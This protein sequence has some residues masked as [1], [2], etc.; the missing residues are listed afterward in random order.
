MARWSPKS[1]HGENK[2]IAEQEMDPGLRTL[3]IIWSAMLM[4][5]AVYLVVGLVVAPRMPSAFTGDTFATLRMA[6]YILG[7]ATLI[8]ARYIRKL[9]LGREDRSVDPAQVQPSSLMAKYTSA[10]IASLAV[11][12]SV[13]I[14]GLVL[15]FLGRNSTDLY[16]LLGISAAALFY[17]RPRKE[18]LAGLS[19]DV[20]F[21]ERSGPWN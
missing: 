16:V 18:E 15:F 9:I 6:L 13:G 17:Y 14:Y 11:C 20:S 8:A 5:V 21:S 1:N 2:M 19:R 7:F 3:K 4:S 10:V 12:E